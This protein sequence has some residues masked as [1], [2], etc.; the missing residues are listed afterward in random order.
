MN[1]NQVSL[2]LIGTTIVGTAAVIIYAF[3]NFVRAEEFHQKIEDVTVLVAYGQYYDRLDDR[4]KSIDEGNV[5]LAEEY[6][7]QM[8]KIKAEIC[9]HDPKWERCKNE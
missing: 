6:E 7:R 8:E 2:G 3:N 4:D 5:D 1:I 9:E